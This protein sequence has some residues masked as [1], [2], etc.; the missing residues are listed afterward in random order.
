[1]VV[2]AKKANLQTRL[3][4]SKVLSYN[5]VVVYHECNVHTV[6]V[7]AQSHTNTSI[8]VEV[9]NEREISRNAFTALTEVKNTSAVTRFRWRGWLALGTN[10]KGKSKSTQEE[11]KLHWSGELNFLLNYR[12]RAW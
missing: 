3:G 4:S 5:D 6:L 8:D 11:S 1:M 2:N 10:E 9:S 7:Q 12:A